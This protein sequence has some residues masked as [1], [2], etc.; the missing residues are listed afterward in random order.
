MP[1][2]P[3]RPLRVLAWLIAT[4]CSAHAGEDGPTAADPSK[5]TAGAMLMT[6]YIYRGIRL[7]DAPPDAGKRQDLA[8]PWNLG[9]F[10]LTVAVM[11][12]HKMTLFRF[13][14]ASPE[15]P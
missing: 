15:N 11:N 1:Q 9:H 6:D 8:F 12:C 4:A 13:P 14:H 5:L 2:L 10:H 3:A 7:Q